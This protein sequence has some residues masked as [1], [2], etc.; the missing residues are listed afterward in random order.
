MASADS[1]GVPAASEQDRSAYLGA[2]LP[3]DAVA[4]TPVAGVLAERPARRRSTTWAPPVP[5]RLAGSARN[6]SI[7]GRAGANRLSGGAGGDVIR[8]G[9]G[10]D[11]IRGGPGADVIRGGPGRDMLMGGGGNDVVRSWGD[12]VADHVDCG[13]G[14]ADRAIVDSADSTE[15]CEV[16]VVRDPSSD[17]RQRVARTV[18]RVRSWDDGHA[19][20]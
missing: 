17:P 19:R 3:A 12:G 1:A 18:S 8:G 13:S 6:E 2:T 9:K 10:A 15:R 20:S 7:V 11:A 4:T 5:T 14:N 16:V